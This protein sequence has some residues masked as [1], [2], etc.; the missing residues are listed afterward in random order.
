MTNAPPDIRPYASQAQACRAL[1]LVTVGL[2]LLGADGLLA[3]WTITDL[4]LTLT[5]VA[6]AALLLLRPNLGSPA[7]Y[8]DTA[9]LAA[10]L[11]SL[12][13]ACLITQAGLYLAS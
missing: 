5:A 3:H 11:Q 1:A 4:P 2:L 7:R 8:D 10:T 9:G 12:V 6:A 13:P